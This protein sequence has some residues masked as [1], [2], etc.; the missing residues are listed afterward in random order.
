[1]MDPRDEID[2][3]AWLSLD[4][5]TCLIRAGLPAPPIV[6]MAT[7]N[8]DDTRTGFY[9]AGEL[10]RP[11]AE[12]LAD[13]RRLIVGHNIAYDMACSLEWY[14]ELRLL[15]ERAYQQNRILDTMLAQRIV[16]IET[17]DKRG[18]LALDQLCSRYGLF[19]E[20]HA[21]DAE[22]N[23][24]RLG[25]GKFLGRPAAEIPQDYTDYAVG[26]PKVTL[27]LFERI[28]SRGL[29]KRRDLGKMAR[30]DLGLKLISAEGLMCDPE[31][32]AAL[33]AQTVERRQILTA[34]LLNAGLVRFERRSPEPI[35]N[36]A[37]I[38]QRVAEAFELPHRRETEWNKS[39]TKAKK[40]QTIYTGS[41]AFFED[42]QNQGL[43]TESG[44]IS[45]GRL[46]LEESGDPLLAALA[47][48]NEWGAVWN[49]DLP[50]FRAAIDVPFHTRFGFAAT[51]RTTSSGPNIQNFRKK[52]GIRE[53][54]FSPG[55]AL[56]A[57]DYSGLENATLA[58]VIAWT[59]GRKG[60]AEKYSSGFDDHSDVGRH[61]VAGIDRTPY[62]TFIAMLE[63][64]DPDAKDYRNSS[65]PLNFGLPG[66]MTRAS[67]VQSYARIGYGVNRPVEFWQAQIDLWYRTQHDKVAYLKD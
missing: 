25:F 66:Y 42:L 12:A 5:E 55:H 24:L 67:T 10:E 39:K 28:L 58:Q 64:G 7:Y 3:Q 43:L 50:I 30:A 44:N 15:I 41:D 46:V 18:K 48:F 2:L 13:E 37:A 32:V 8:F 21:V 45:T 36:I 49:K 11:L 63:S 51:T 29:V 22:E 62:E 23:K 52:A 6:C 35:K 14:P 31:R 65:K 56:V 17:G 16:E 34:E 20:K 9:G 61:M 59:L 60:P 4:D 57:T 38:R 47:E 54:I 53:C 27:K 33:Q 26:D 40:D 1:M 19:V